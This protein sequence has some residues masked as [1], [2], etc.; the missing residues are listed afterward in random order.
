MHG[1]QGRGWPSG[2]SGLSGEGPRDKRQKRQHKEEPTE[3]LEERG[4]VHK[5]FLESGRLLSE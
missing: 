2:G 5:T 1:V 3:V 4:E